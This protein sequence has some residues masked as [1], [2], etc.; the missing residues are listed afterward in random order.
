M[1]LHVQGRFDEADHQ[2]ILSLLRDRVKEHG[3]IWLFLWNQ[4]SP[5]L[6]EANSPAWIDPLLDEEVRKGLERIALVIPPASTSWFEMLTRSLPDSELRQFAESDQEN[7][8]HWVQTG[9]AE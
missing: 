9:P 5:N 2:A 7:A 3:R 8:L 6:V 1:I 4:S